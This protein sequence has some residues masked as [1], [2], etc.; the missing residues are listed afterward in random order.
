[1]FVF[2]VRSQAV[3][4]YVE[5]P[6]SVKDLSVKLEGVFILRYRCFDLL[7][8]PV[9]QERPALAECFGEPFRVSA[10]LR[11]DGSLN[12]LSL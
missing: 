7:S 8:L 10:F 9:T 1:M 6:D 5:S 3:A 11:H 4:T 12:V 2:S